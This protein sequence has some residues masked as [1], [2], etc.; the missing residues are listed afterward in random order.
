MKHLRKI[1]VALFLIL[2]WGV[3]WKYCEDNFGSKVRL[4]VDVWDLRTYYNNGKWFP[5]V[6]QPYVDVPSE[7]PQVATYL[8]GWVHWF[9]IDLPRRGLAREIYFRA[10][11][12]IMLLTGY[13]T[14]LLLEHMKERKKWIPLLLFLPGPLYFVFNRYDILPAFLCLLAFFFIKRLN[15]PIAA[16]LLAVATMTKWYAILL[17]PSFVAYAWFVDKKIP[18]KSVVVFA[19]TIILIALPTYITGGVDGLLLP[20]QFHMNRASEAASL[21]SLVVSGFPVEPIIAKIVIWVFFGLQLLASAVSLMFRI[22]S[23]EGLASWWILCVGGFVLFS[24]IYSPQWILWVLPMLLL[25]VEDAFDVGLIILYGTLTYIGFPLVYDGM[26]SAMLFVHLSNLAL[27][28]TLMLRSTTR[29]SWKFA[30][31]FTY[32]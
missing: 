21:P 15:W 10:F 25:E 8:F 11:R 19:L 12:L 18:W 3:I 1:L 28:F 2:F 26:R 27:L 17:M 20:Y 31:P 7:Y 9:V 32:S 4:F 24:R 23:I 6:L 22:D 29:I 30:N 14:F 13:A 16:F 5:A